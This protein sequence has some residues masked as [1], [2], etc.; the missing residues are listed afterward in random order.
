MQLTEENQ[1]L[2][3]HYSTSIEGNPLSPFDV[4]NIILGDQ[5]PITKS[6]KAVKMTDI[7][8]VLAVTRQQSH[9]L[10]ASLVKKGLL[11]KFCITK[12]SYYKL[13]KKNEAN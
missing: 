5:I 1:V 3:T 12:T 8:D 13:A 7:Q 4:T 6:E 2:A 9:A 11:E 10:L